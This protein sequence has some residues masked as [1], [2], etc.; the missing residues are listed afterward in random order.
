MTAEAVVVADAEAVVVAVAVPG[1]SAI[2]VGD[3]VEDE[4]T[5]AW[6]H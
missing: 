6:N 3:F 5:L 1:S 2:V 4:L